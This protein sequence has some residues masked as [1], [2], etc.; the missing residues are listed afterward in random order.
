MYCVRASIIVFDL[1]MTESSKTKIA[2]TVELLEKSN[3]FVAP[4]NKLYTEIPRRNIVTPV[5]ISILRNYNTIEDY[6]SD[7]KVA[8]IFSIAMRII[9]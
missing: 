9:L 1:A 4:I 5:A 3:N 7:L 2:A 8:V 6:I